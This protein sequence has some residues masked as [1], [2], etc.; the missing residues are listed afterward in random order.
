MK[1]SVVVP[2]YKDSKFLE[3]F[4][5][6]MQHQE[7]QDFELVLVID[8]NG[9]NVLK[10]VNDFKNV[11]QNNFALIYNSK[12][13]GRTKAIYDGV[14]KAS[15]DY[16]LIC[17]TSDIVV[18]DAIKELISLIEIQSTDIIEFMPRMR[19]PIRFKG[20]LRKEF[21]STNLIDDASPI[22]YI[23]P[24]DFN[25]LFLRPVLLK[26]LDDEDYNKI[27]NTRFAITYILKSFYY[28]K[29]YSN[30]SKKIILSKLNN[31]VELSPLI[32]AKQ[33]EG[34]RRYI[35]NKHSNKYLQ[36]FDY[37]SYYH[38]VVIL[39]RF[40]DLLKNK[41]IT[42]KYRKYLQKQIE[43]YFSKKID[44]NKYFLADNDE[45][46]AFREAKSFNDY[47][48]LLRSLN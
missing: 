10:I 27:I 24:F 36:E 30:V 2:V 46:K 47:S 1:L 11:F 19:N 9:E 33:W 41:K 7:I 13:S 25:K 35:A 48:K 15:G 18:K 14:K 44:N 28:A 16:I 40:V 45:T 38:E 6:E 17:S 29:T 8:T 23:F 5:V 39:T 21:K 3:R 4:L 32:I 12:R 20:F 34:L 42:D 37:L 31:L 26:A 22:A 43:Q